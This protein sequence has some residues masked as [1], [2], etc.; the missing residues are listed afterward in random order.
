MTGTIVAIHT[1]SPTV[2]AIEFSTEPRLDFS[3]GQYIEAKLPGLEWTPFSLASSPQDP[4]AQLCIKEMPEHKAELDALQPGQSFPLKAADGGLLYRSDG[5]RPVCLI[6]TGTGIAPLRSILRSRRQ[7]GLLAPETTLLFGVFSQDEILYK[8][9]WAQEGVHF[10]PCLS[11]PQPG[12]DG[13][14]GMVGDAIRQG[15]LALNWPEVD[16]YLCGHTEMVQEIKA[17]LM[18]LGTPRSAI[19]HELFI[20]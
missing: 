11:D 19:V 18:E 5:S 14:H 15:H 10:V 6:G 13:F 9:E 3:A 8:D 17:L 2:K 20:P 12:W 16:V 7:Q 4:T 1:L